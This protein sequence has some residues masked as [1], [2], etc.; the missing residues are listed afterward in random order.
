MLTLVLWYDPKISGLFLYT[1]TK[2]IVS[3]DFSGDYFFPVVLSSP[4]LTK[5]GGAPFPT[6]AELKIFS[7]FSL[8]G[9]TLKFDSCT[10]LKC[11]IVVL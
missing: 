11:F 3:V 5:L 9:E 4:G 8:I 2:L 7:K 10:L 1:L 6:L